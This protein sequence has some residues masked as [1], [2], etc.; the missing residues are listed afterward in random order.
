VGIDSE[1]KN[2]EMYEEFLKFVKEQVVIDAFKYLQAASRDNHLL[3]FTRCSEGGM[4][5]GPG[6]GRGRP[7]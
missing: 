1:K 2:I 6:N 7:F 5:R 3:A 4:G